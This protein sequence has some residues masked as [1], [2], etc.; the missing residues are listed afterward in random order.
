MC[1]NR[2]DA[3]D[4]AVIRRAAEI[5]VFGRPDAENRRKL[6]SPK[7]DELGFDEDE[8]DA[9]VA[10]TGPRDGRAGF[11]FSDLTQR[12]IPAIVLDAYPDRPILPDRALKIAQEMAA[13]A[14]FIDRR[15]GAR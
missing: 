1:T 3:L 2:Y 11:T 8:I 4:P 12:L 9:I 5:L 7:L 6:L 10:A 14:P 15:T 13:T